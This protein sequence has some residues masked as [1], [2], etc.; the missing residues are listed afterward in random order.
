MIEAFRLMKHMYCI[1]ITLNFTITY[2]EALQVGSLEDDSVY[3]II[4]FSI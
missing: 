3:L 1:F 2:L 4:L